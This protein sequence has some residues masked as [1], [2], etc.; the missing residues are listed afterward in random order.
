MDSLDIHKTICNQIHSTYERKNADYGDAFG[1]SVDEF[2]ISAAM[3][4]ISDKYYRA[5]NLVK[6]HT[7]QVASEALEDTLLDMANYCIMT[8]MKMKEA[9]Q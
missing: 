3:V 6:G 4:R 8:V 2:G 5:L 7:P 9:E 1:R